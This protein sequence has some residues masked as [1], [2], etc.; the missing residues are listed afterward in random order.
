VQYEIIVCTKT[1]LQPFL[2]RIARNWTLNSRHQAG[3]FHAM[4]ATTSRCA[5]IIPEPKAP[6]EIH[7]FNVAAPPLDSITVKLDFAGICGTDPHLW[8]GDFPLP[9]PI[10]LGHEGIG[11]VLSMHKA[12]T[13]DHASEPLQV[14]DRVYWTGIRPCRKCYYCTILND[15]CGCPNSFFMHGFDDAAGV[16]GTWATYTEVATIGPRNSFYEMDPNVPPEAFRALGY[17]L[18]TFAPSY[19]APSQGSNPD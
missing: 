7:S 5:G 9:G 2:S 12:V 16:K 14:G 11:T 19:R 1:S 17:A 13:T 8:K 15:E 3:H 4:A 10:I 6:V 18:P